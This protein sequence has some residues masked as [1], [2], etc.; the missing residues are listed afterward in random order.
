MQHE[1]FS[2]RVHAVPV[3]GEDA[4]A[5]GSQIVN[6]VLQTAGGCHAHA[7]VGM[8]ARADPTCPRK[9]GHGTRNIIYLTVNKR[10]NSWYLPSQRRCIAFLTTNRADLPRCTGHLQA[11]GGLMKI[12]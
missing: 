7:C 10:T 3:P 9:R 4:G 1:M 12:G 6:V 2:R 5:I 8:Y 11:K